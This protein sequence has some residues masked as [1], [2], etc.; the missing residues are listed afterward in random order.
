VRLGIEQHDAQR[1]LG[2]STEPLLATRAY[3]RKNVGY[4]YA[5]LH[6]AATIYETDDDNALSVPAVPLPS[7]A[8]LGL[9]GFC[10]ISAR[11]RRT[12]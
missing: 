2:L 1:A 6:G 12:A 4:L 8:G 9:A 7:A 3:T 5:A 11:R 10:A